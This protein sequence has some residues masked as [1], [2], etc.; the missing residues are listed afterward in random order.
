MKFILL[1]ILFFISDIFACPGGADVECNKE[2]VSFSEELIEGVPLPREVC[3]A[4]YNGEGDE[5]VFSYESE[6]NS[7]NYD[8]EK[9]EHY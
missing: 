1:F 5:V 9:N 8:E 4:H 6:D 3:G 2:D 7:S